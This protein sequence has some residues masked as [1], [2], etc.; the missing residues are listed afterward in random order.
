MTT[1]NSKAVVYS[2]RMDNLTTQKW[3]VRN[4]TQKTIK[5]MRRK[6]SKWGC[7]HE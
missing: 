3:T 7:S 5:T 6:T 4:L 2:H 1:G